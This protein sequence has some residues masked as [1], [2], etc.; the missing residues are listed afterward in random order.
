MF[1]FPPLSLA[2]HVLSFI[3]VLSTLLSSIPF[4]SFPTKENY[5]PRYAI[6]ASPSSKCIEK[7]PN[8]S[9]NCNLASLIRNYM[10]LWAHII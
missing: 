4:A 3:H 7:L 9:K 8:G 6:S 5:Q 2:P 1:S 10:L